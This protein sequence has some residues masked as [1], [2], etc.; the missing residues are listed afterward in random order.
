LARVPQILQVATADYFRVRVGAVAVDPL[1][2]GLA[3]GLAGVYQI[4]FV[5]PPDLPDGP[6]EI[7]LIRYVC[8]AFFGSCQ[9]GGGQ[10]VAYTSSPVIIPVRR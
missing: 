3:P 10:R 9:A 8:T 4:N 6:T 7:Q 5:L 1:F 2:V